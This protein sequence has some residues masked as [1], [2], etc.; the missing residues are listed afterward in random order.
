VAKTWFW[1]VYGCFVKLQKSRISYVYWFI[2]LEKNLR[3]IWTIETEIYGLDLNKMK[4][5]F[6]SN[7]DRPSKIRWLDNFP[8]TSAWSNRTEPPGRHGKW[9]ES[10]G[11][12]YGALNF[13]LILPTWFRWHKG[14]VLLTCGSGNRPHE[15]IDGEAARS[16]V[17]N[18]EG[19][20]RRCSGFKGVRRSFLVLP[21]SFLS[22]QLLQTVAENLNLVAT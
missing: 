21:S 6:H 20:L 17:G 22:G 5:C 19:V 13:G 1:K 4:G 12:H 8:S 15:V 10:L 18:D 16:A 3:L 11:S 9:Q 7:L 14:S 2:F